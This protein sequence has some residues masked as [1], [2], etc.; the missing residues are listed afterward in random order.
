[1]YLNKH[2]VIRYLWSIPHNFECKL[3]IFW[4]SWKIAWPR[5]E[6]NQSSTEFKYAR[7]G[8]GPA[9]PRW[10]WNQS[11]TE[12]KYARDGEGPDLWINVD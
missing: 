10:E 7:D 5:W 3:I 9:W 2:L 8:E 12:F 1:M 11:S 6:W 4:A